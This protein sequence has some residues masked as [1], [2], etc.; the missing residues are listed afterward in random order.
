MTVY[1]DI[2]AANWS[3][4][5]YMDTCD[6]AYRH[7][8]IHPHMDTQAFALG[9]A[10]HVVW[11]GGRR[12]SRR[13]NA[14]RDA[15]LE[16][17]RKPLEESERNVALRMEEAVHGQSA[18]AEA[19]TDGRTEVPVCWSNSDTGVACKSRVDYLT[20]NLLID[21]KTA[22]SVTPRS[23]AASVVNYGTHGQI[24]YYVDGCRRAGHSPGYM[25][26]PLV[27]AVEK[28]APFDMVV[29][30]VGGYVIEAGRALY[31]KCLRRLVE[32]QRSGGWPGAAPEGVPL[33][34]PPWALEP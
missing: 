28:S 20:S 22:Q 21:L 10:V 9:L 24:A 7:A 32:C 27:I 12:Y 33:E 34:L 26:P 5:N 29:Y 2:D 11:D 31:K 6:A 15:A 30:Q 1:D 14:F 8:V 3:T 19:H 13:W 17:G 18:A 16:S 25:D 4:L 23:F